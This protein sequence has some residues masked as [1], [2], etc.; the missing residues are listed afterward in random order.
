MK[1]KTLWL[2]A[3]MLLLPTWTL[4]AQGSCDTLTLPYFCDFD[5]TDA[6]LMPDCWLRPL[7]DTSYEDVYPA[8]EAYLT[9]AHSGNNFLRFTSFGTHSNMAVTPVVPLPANRM[10]ITFWLRTYN[11]VANSTFEVGLIADTANAASFHPLM[12]ITDHSYF[13]VYYDFQT[14]TLSLNDTMRLAFRSSGSQATIF[15]IDDLTIERGGGC[16]M[17]YNF[18]LAQA[19]STWALL[20]WSHDGGE[21]GYLLTLDDSLEYTTTD[22][23]LL[24]DSLQANAIYNISLQTIC[25]MGDT[26]AKVWL[27]FRT[28][29]TAIDTPYFEDFTTYGNLTFPLCWEIVSGAYQTAQGWYPAV[30]QGNLQLLNYNGESVIVCTAP[31]R[32]APNALHIS[33]RKYSSMYGVLEAGV[34]TDI[35][36][37]MSFVPILTIPGDES[38]PIGDYEYYTDGL[39]LPDTVQV[40]V[41]FRWRG[42]NGHALIYNM[43]IEAA[44]GCHPPTQLTI[45]DVTSMGAELHWV[46][47][48]Q[49]SVG[50]EVR[51]NTVNTIP[52]DADSNGV[53]TLDTTVGFTHLNNNTNYYFWVRSLCDEDSVWV[54]FPMIRTSCGE[55]QAPYLETFESYQWMATPACWEYRHQDSTSHLEPTVDS[56]ILYSH[57]GLK[58]LQLMAW[59]YDTLTALMPRIHNANANELH[60]TFW[61]AHTQGVFEAGVMTLTDSVFIPY[62]TA[63][64]S[65]GV[66]PVYHEFYTSQLWTTDSVRVAF[67]W[68]PGPLTSNYQYMQRYAYL[69]DV[70]VRH[71]GACRHADSLELATVDTST[72][73]LHVYDHTENGNYR[74]YYTPLFGGSVDSV[75][76][77]GYDATLTGLRHS[78]RYRAWVRSI[79]YDGSLTDSVW[80]LFNTECVTLTHDNLPYVEGFDDYTPGAGQ[81]ISPCWTLHNFNGYYGQGFPAPD[82]NFHTGSSGNS[83][84]FSI[85]RRVASQ[86]AVLPEVDYVNDLFV[87]FYGYSQITCAVEVGVMDNPYDTNTFFTLQ[88]HTMSTNFTLYSTRL[89]EYHG[90]GRYIALRGYY[91]GSGT[92][93]LSSVFLDDVKVG[94]TPPCMSEISQLT[95]D[96]AWTERADFSWSVGLGNTENASYVVHLLDSTGTELD[97]FSCRETEY[98]MYG[99]NSFTRYR[100]YVDLLC[101]EADSVIA[102]TDTLAFMTAC[103]MSER[104][105]LSN[106]DSSNT[107]MASLLLPA[108][109]SYYPS[110]SQQIFTPEDFDNATGNITA[111]IFK[112][113][114]QGSITQR[115]CQIYL[116]YTTADS[117]T[118]LMPYD[119]SDIYYDGALLSAVGWNFYNL[120]K[121]FYYNGHGNLMVTFV[122]NGAQIPVPPTF[123]CNRLWNGVSIVTELD[124]LGNVIHTPSSLRN[125]MRV[126]FCPDET[127]FCNPPM[128]DSVTADDMSID[129]YYPANRVYEVHIM[130]GWWNRGVSGTL[131][132]SGH[133]RFD[134]NIQ[135]GTLYTV[136]LR[137]HC[138]NGSV[139][140]WSLRR[141]TTDSISSLFTIALDIV[142]TS[143][144]SATLHWSSSSDIDTGLWEVHLFNTLIDET[145]TTTTREVT[146]DQ[147]TSGVTYYATVREFRGSHRNIPSEWS[148]TIS[149]T[150]NTCQPI[151]NLTFQVVDDN[152]VILQWDER[153]G[154][155]RWRLEYGYEGF[156]R[157]EAIGAYTIIENPYTIHGLEPG[158]TYQAYIASVCDA[159]SSSVWS[160]PVT[161][162]TTGEVGITEAGRTVRG[163]TLYPNPATTSVT[164]VSNDYPATLDII[165]INGRR[166]MSVDINAEVTQVDISA[167]T[168]G[169]YFLRLVS[170]QHSAVGKLIKR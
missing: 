135:S 54:A 170:P 104:L 63:T 59:R 70:Q 25:P 103:D 74:V 23:V 75:D 60:V 113:R 32:L 158:T 98:S 122:S 132:S 163:I 31:V 91:T 92:Q 6:G 69:D 49:E 128:I 65:N 125:L 117:L 140:M 151:E 67:R 4:R 18:R 78:T 105:N 19:D 99:L 40:R 107:A 12:T 57:S 22:T 147:L 143:R 17:P 157:G 115:N 43:R 48:S 9:E 83:L 11:S 37:T 94:I 41:A 55:A 123:D 136:G 149:F 145:V 51:Y 110:T 14:D 161:F 127:D 101:D 62:Y 29:C 66:T 24:L 119:S 169:H 130:R 72:A 167:L 124:S 120:Q 146:F 77:Y 159:T 156:S 133:F 35:T 86:L 68:A 109:V 30:H 139:S 160:R 16:P 155:E 134:D 164:V 73:V 165:D 87:S 153:N 152:T 42:Q 5:S 141:I 27:N 89:N 2:M 13:W 106:Y 131:D 80:T 116:Q 84:E 144:T 26:T 36:D 1:K 64:T 56:S 10:H 58:T 95:L 150:T 88:R 50:Y 20:T 8:V 100:V 112:A 79:C 114:R 7:T 90:T 28:A 81:P 137:S 96:G 38:N 52:P 166:L 46:D 34:I 61:V 39:T 15:L 129:V 126:D 33:F 168:R 45:T 53:F 44:G 162:T 3:A 154:S 148:D 47:H 108:I 102:R 85:G 121:P 118:S 138:D 71:V 142:E 82:S 76:I 111:L 21:N 93:G 97:S